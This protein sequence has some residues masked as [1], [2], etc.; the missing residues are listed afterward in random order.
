MRL[1]LH[2]GE[3]SIKGDGIDSVGDFTISGRYAQSEVEF[4][5]VHPSDTIA[6]NGVWDGAM[7]AGLWRFRRPMRGI[8]N[9]GEFEIWPEADDEA[10][11]RMES[12]LSA[13]G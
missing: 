2:F 7:I 3:T 4:D 12:A 5:K 8:V 9:E 11:E 6:Y 13:V 10:I 1:S